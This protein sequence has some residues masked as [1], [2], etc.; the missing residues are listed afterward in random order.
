MLPSVS[1]PIAKPTSPAAVAAPGPA[2]EP[3][4]SFL[5]QPRVHGL[6][7]EP[8]IVERESTHAE[9]PQLG[10]RLRH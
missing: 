1:L 2:L 9:L 3:R 8:D 6:S 5:E 4:R 10:P 7:A